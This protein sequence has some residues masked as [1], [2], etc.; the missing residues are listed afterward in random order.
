MS[1]ITI[2]GGGVAGLTAAS[3]L[4]RDGHEVHLFEAEDQF[5]YHASGRS[6]AMFEENYGNAVV[7]ALN[8]ATG[9]VLDAVGV[10]SPR[11][12]LMVARESEGDLFQRDLNA[13][14]MEEIALDQ[15]RSHI[16]IL[17]DAVAYAAVHCG[18]KDIDTDAVLQSAAKDARRR[19]AALHTKAKVTAIHP[20]RSVTAN[21]AE[22]P[23]HLVVNAAGAWA[24]RIAA[25]AGVQTIGLMP[26][27]R[28]MARLPAPGGHDVR[29]WPMLFGAGERWYAKPDAG[30]W[31]VSPAEEDPVDAM[32]AWADDM[33]LAEG[34]ARYEAHV[35][36]PITRMETNW[37]GL[38]S[39]APDRALVIGAD[40]ENADFFWLAGQGGYGFQ[41]CMA[42]ANHLAALIGHRPSALGHEVTKALSPGR[43][44]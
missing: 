15:A 8:R 34:L 2:I 32:D 5:G 23:T 42:A 9:P 24:D 36:E 17:S 25:L 12:I 44:R 39:F 29:A 11:G 16:P 28:S 19:G 33:V 26:F 21:G 41:T 18:A 7:R 43:F 31:L 38:R 37:A 10:L 13:M 30:L 27:R 35:T 3:A 6:A 40:P 22:H 14:G 1:R 4:A 20:G